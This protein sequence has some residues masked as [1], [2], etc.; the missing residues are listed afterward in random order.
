MDWDPYDAGA[1]KRPLKTDLET[2]YELTGGDLSRSSLKNDREAVQYYC[3]RR[4]NNI[5]HVD[6]SVKADYEFMFNLMTARDLQAPPTL[7]R[8]MCEHANFMSHVP[9]DAG[10]I[11]YACRQFEQ[12]HFVGGP[13]WK[14]RE[15][16]FINAVLG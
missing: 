8:M 5:K 13:A 2:D 11:A 7:G 3:V 6:P 1:S 4:H 12:I 15:K 10:F 14:N 16:E 9:I